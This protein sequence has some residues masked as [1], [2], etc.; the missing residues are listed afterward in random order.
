M[1]TRSSHVC[2]PS[3]VCSYQR[4]SRDSRKELPG[5]LLDLIRTHRGQFDQVSGG[6]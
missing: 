6:R 1:H 4:E 3:A 5:G 2:A